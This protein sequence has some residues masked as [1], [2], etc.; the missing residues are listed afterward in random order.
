[1]VFYLSFRFQLT[2]YAFLTSILYYGSHLI[3]TGLLTYG[4]LSAFLLYA[5]FCS[6]SISNIQGFYTELM[7]GLGASARLFELRDVKPHIPIHGKN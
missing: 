4:D 7:R 1:M 2:G 3:S 6:A 5:V